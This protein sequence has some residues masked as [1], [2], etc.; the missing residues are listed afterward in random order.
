[1]KHVN[2]TWITV[3]VNLFECFMMLAHDCDAVAVTTCSVSWLCFGAT[4]YLW[5]RTVCLGAARLW[6]A[7][8]WL[9]SLVAHLVFWIYVV[10]VPPLSLSRVC[11]RWGL[12]TI[13]EECKHLINTSSFILAA[14]HLAGFD[15]Y[16][17][18]FYL[19]LTH[20]SDKCLSNFYYQLFHLFLHITSL[21]V[22]T[23]I[24]ILNVIAA[25]NTHWGSLLWLDRTTRLGV[26]RLP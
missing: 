15:F 18:L 5:H 2:V 3:Q 10:S 7:R 22:K 17:V 19:L 13:S 20:C 12:H 8:L 24:E 23:V 16:F 1:M 6:V 26:C 21:S 25:Q 14:T 9:L 11:C 4:V